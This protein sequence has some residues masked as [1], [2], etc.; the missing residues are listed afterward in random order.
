MKPVSK[1]T[2]GELG[3]FIQSQLREKVN[4]VILSGNK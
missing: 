1:M 2:Q 4:E 3:A